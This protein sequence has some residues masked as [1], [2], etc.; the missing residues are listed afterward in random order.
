MITVKH[1]NVKNGYDTV[2]Q[3]ILSSIR[4]SRIPF[5]SIHGKEHLHLDQNS[6]V[7]SHTA[8]SVP[9]PI[10]PKANLP[11]KI[12]FRKL[13]HFAQGEE[14]KTATFSPPIGNPLQTLERRK[15]Q[16]AMAT[17][18]RWQKYSSV[19][20]PRIPDRNPRNTDTGRLSMTLF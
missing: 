16:C 8:S 17:C 14:K 19:G 13:A 11:L 1:T 18:R 12:S 3:A 6:K 15:G 9:N 7:H 10:P 5:K 4:N 2:S 20:M